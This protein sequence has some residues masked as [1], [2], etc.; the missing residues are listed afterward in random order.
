VRAK[1]TALV[2]LTVLTLCIPAFGDAFAQ[3]QTTQPFDNASLRAEQR[4][5][6]LMTVWSEAKYN[7]PWFDKLPD[8]NWDAAAEAYLPRVIAARDTVEY[9]RLLMEFAVLLKDGHTAVRPPWF[10]FLPTED[11]L[12]LEV[13][14][15]DDKVIIV[16]AGDTGEIK[17]Q[18]IYPGLEILEA[19]GTSIQAYFQDKVYRYYTA[20]SEHGNQVWGVFLFFGARNS[21]IDLKV[22]DMDGRL[23]T[24][25]L[26]RNLF[27]SRGDFFP[28]Y[29]RWNVIE[30]NLEVKTLRGGI[31]YVRIPSFAIQGIEDEFNTMIDGLDAKTVK[32]MIID[33]RFN[34][35]GNSSTAEKMIA[36]LIDKE[37]SSPTMKYPQYVGAYRAWGKKTELMES[38]TVIVPRQGKRYLGPIVVLTGMATA[39]TAEDFAIE[40]KFAGRALLIGEKTAGSAGNT[41]GFPLPGGGSFEVSTFRAYLPDGAEY[42]H[43]GVAPDIEVKTTQKEIY[44]GLEPILARGLEVIRKWPEFQQRPKEGR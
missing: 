1:R 36:C 22:K 43:I 17:K 29:M 19:E 3:E 23:R 42:V 24:V 10:P 13:R 11:T 30:R 15:I 25:S 31:L 41:L 12:P 18:R 7:F 37:V 39:S 28:Q 26:T 34:S 35:G 38:K 8:L 32:G 44:K 40:L 9:Y 2:W 20:G 21:V 4:I 5:M 16:A 27:S 14:I 33:L 6:G